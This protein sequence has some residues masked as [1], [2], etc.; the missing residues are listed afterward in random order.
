MP[1]TPVSFDHFWTYSQA[2]YNAVIE[3]TIFLG[4]GWCSTPTLLLLR[5]SFSGEENGH[6]NSPWILINKRSPVLFLYTFVKKVDANHSP[7]DGWFGFGANQNNQAP[8]KRNE[9][10]SGMVKTTILLIRPVKTEHLPNSFSFSKKVHHPWRPLS[11]PRYHRVVINTKKSTWHPKSQIGWPTFVPWRRCHQQATGANSL[12]RAPL[13][14]GT[15]KSMECHRPPQ[16][17]FF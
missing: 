1:G 16:P 9:D 11:L 10:K 6:P 12:A 2:A 4:P 17:T 8:L 13:Q 5:S 3:P 7:N 14:V 15:G